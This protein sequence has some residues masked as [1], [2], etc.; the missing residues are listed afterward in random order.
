MH[1][2]TSYNCH[3]LTCATFDGAMVAVLKGPKDEDDL[4]TCVHVSHINF[5]HLFLLAVLL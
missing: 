1:L 3:H 5:H 2:T 4:P